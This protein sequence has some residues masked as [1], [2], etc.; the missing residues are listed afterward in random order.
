MSTSRPA[1]ASPAAWWRLAALTP[2]A[3]VLLAVPAAATGYVDAAAAGL[4]RDQ[5]YVDPGATAIVSEQAASQLRGSVD[6]A[7]T[8]IFIAVLPVAARQEAGGSTESLGRQIAG[9]VAQPGAYMV[10]AGDQWAA[11]DVGGTLPDGRAAALGTTAFRANGSDAQAALLQWVDGVAT[12]AREGGQSQ[13]GGAAQGGQVDTVGS[14][15]TGGGRGGAG[16]TIA[17]VAVVTLLLVGGGALVFG[18]R[19]RR[20]ERARELA[21]VKTVAQEDLI[22]LGED[23]R[24]LDIDT[25]MPGADPEAVRHHAEAVDAY[26][27]AA[28]ILDRAARPQDL[29]GMSAALETGRFSMASARAILEGRPPPERRP[30][31]FFDPR[32]GPS[33]ED[34][35]WT[36]PGGI[37]RTVPACAADAQRVH[38]GVEPESRQVL[39]GTGGR[40]PY[41]N[42]PGYY[43][44][45]FGGYFGGFGGMGGLFTGFLLGSALGGWGYPV[46]VGGDGGDGSGDGGG[47]GD[48]G[49]DA[50]DTGGDWGGGDWGGGDV[51]G[52]G[53]WGGGDFGGGDFG[54]GGE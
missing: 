38:D 35:E 18:V 27:R 48:G 49:G 51:G 10:I 44:P 15:G 12:A 14:G 28:R 50:G 5:V 43:A 29:A 30:P 53:D 6:G 22:A 39:T 32:H 37:P 33:T 9:K 36:P 17:G 47:E 16:G 13:P 54:G 23:I 7:G 34:V 3:L 20:R 21:E 24:A 52:G 31:C 8:P 46:Y 2:A 41:Y 4:R 45:W 26:Q 11:G 42:A 19:R 25:S 1:S 40:V